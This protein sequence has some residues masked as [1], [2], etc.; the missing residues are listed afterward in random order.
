MTTIPQTTPNNERM[1]SSF[2]TIKVETNRRKALNKNF[3][4]LRL[5][6]WLSTKKSCEIS[7]H[8]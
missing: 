2:V 8:V 4:N 6:D 3:L 5:F 7:K 1:K